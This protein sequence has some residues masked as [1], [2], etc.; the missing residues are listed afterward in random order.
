MKESL[1]FRR[2]PY[3]RTD[4]YLVE[5]KAQSFCRPYGLKHF[6]NIRVINIIQTVLQ[7]KKDGFVKHLHLGIYV[8]CSNQSIVLNKP[9]FVILKTQCCN[10]GYFF[11]GSNDNRIGI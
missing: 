8:I 2:V 11:E 9:F 7:R 6:L 3:R 5:L 10:V 4:I 1:N